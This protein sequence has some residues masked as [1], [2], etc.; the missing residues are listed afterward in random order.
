MLLLLRP[1][2]ETEL[3]AKKTGELR[4][5]PHGGCK[6]FPAGPSVQGR[7]LARGHRWSQVVSLGLF[8]RLVQ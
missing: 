1:P 7:M 3:K 2:S 5:E 8:V 6:P 4:G